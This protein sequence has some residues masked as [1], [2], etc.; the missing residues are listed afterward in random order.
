MDLCISCGWTSVAV[1]PHGEA[2][3]IILC[4]GS[5]NAE[6]RKWEVV[7]VDVADIVGQ[8][9]LG[10]AGDILSKYLAGRILEVSPVLKRIAI[11]AQSE[12]TL[13]AV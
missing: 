4:I 1:E 2:K 6:L 13:W 12:L 3:L 5:G 9:D 8:L 11:I 7:D 10:E